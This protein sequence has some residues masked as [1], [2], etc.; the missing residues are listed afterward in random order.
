MQD[1]AHNDFV[2][3]FPAHWMDSSVV[4]LSGPPNGGFSPNVTIT[5]ERLEFQLDCTAYARNQLAMLR[6]ELAPAGYKVIEEGVLQLAGINAY[7]RIHTFRVADADAQVTQLQVYVV[8]GAEAVTITCSHL[9]PWFDQ[10]R[11][12]FTEAIHRFKWPAPTP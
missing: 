6:Q 7:Q 5:R 8:K 10:M 11:P 1:F 9:A 3:G 2:I 12:V 4:I